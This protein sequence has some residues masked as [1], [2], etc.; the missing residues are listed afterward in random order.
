M[1][2]IN[3]IRT[4]NCLCF[5]MLLI[6]INYGQCQLNY[7]LDY[8][9]IPEIKDAGGKIYVP[10][11]KTSNA[12]KVNQNFAQIYFIDGFNNECVALFNSKRLVF[13]TKI[14][15]NSSG[16]AKILKLKK[17]DTA[18][19]IKFKINNCVTDIISIEKKY[20]YLLINYE[21]E[22]QTISIKFTNKIIYYD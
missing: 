21:S 14:S 16:Y 20:D 1:L 15:T 18:K 5:F 8:D 22:T 7:K 9:T 6:K 17:F 19:G 2:K 11:I 4:A 12:R 10:E 13:S 3:K